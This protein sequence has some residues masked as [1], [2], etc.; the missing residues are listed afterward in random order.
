MLTCC[1]RL[2]SFVATCSFFGYSALIK[3]CFLLDYTWMSAQ[4]EAM[5]LSLMYSLASGWYAAWMTAGLIFR[6]QY[7]LPVEIPYYL[8]GGEPPTG[9]G[10][11][12]LE[13]PFF[14][15]TFALMAILHFV[16]LGAKVWR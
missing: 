15:S 3:T 12:P 11:I 16:A 1:W 8:S 10:P 5:T 9:R 6:G 14:C 2:G 13:L 7:N 4:S